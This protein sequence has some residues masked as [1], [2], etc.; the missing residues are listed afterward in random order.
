MTNLFVFDIDGTLLSAGGAGVLAINQVFEEAFG[1]EN[2]CRH[3]TFAGATDKNLF[4]RAQNIAAEASG[5][6]PISEEEIFSLYATA[7]ENELKRQNT[8]QAYDGVVELLDVL[9][10]NEQAILGI[11]TGNLAAT[12]R[13]KL[14][15]AG[16]EHY[17]GFGGYGSDHEQRADI[18]KTAV[19]RGAASLPLPPSRTIVFG[20]TPKD[21]WA[22]RA[23]GAEVIA[24]TTGSFDAEA[25]AQE[26]PDLVTPSLASSEV[27][28]F[29]KITP[30]LRPNL[31]G[32]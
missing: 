25:L 8:C 26:K 32:R 11:G 29:L 20:D 3:L 22:A 14:R 6:D 19:M 1:Y 24:V 9:Q 23:I 4:A 7:F 16:L 28:R 31:A 17:F 27:Y 18:F 12:A 10:K 5:K 15:Y 30:E 21:I 13:L 2:M